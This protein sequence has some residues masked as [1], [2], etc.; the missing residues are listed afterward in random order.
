[1]LYKNKLLRYWYIL[2]SYLNTVKTLLNNYYADYCMCKIQSRSTY[3]NDKKINVNILGF[4]AV[5]MEKLFLS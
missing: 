3:T 2:Q 4:F 1:M 5:V